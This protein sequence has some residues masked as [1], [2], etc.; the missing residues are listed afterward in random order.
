MIGIPLSE[1]TLEFYN[2]II[3]V[4][5]FDILPDEAQEYLINLAFDLPSDIPYSERF[6]IMGYETGYIFKNIFCGFLFFAIGIMTKLFQFIV[7]KCHCKPDKRK[8]YGKKASQVYGM[9]IK[10]V[11]ELSLDIAIAGVCELILKQ[12]TTPS[13]KASYYTSLCLLTILAYG[14]F[15]V[16]ELIYQNIFKIRNPLLFPSLHTKWSVLWE[17]LRLSHTLPI[18]NIFFIIRRITYALIIVL[19]PLINLPITF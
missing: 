12:N 19:S 14:I 1:S 10:F 17:D 5:T 8:H 3:S 9:S 4:V 13:E 18:F 2:V 7:S 6:V 11:I 15:H 16:K